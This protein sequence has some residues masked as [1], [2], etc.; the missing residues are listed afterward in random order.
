MLPK[1]IHKVVALVSVFLFFCWLFY[2]LNIGVPTGYAF[3]PP[4]ISFAAV[5]TFLCVLVFI[6]VDSLLTRN[7]QKR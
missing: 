3:R 6:L 7:K 2:S 5:A 4:F 1:P